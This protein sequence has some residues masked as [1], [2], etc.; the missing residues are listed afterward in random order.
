MHLPPVKVR[1]SGSDWLQPN[2]SLY[3]RALAG[4]L[5]GPRSTQRP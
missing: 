2:G 3:R 5:A 1:D 4:W